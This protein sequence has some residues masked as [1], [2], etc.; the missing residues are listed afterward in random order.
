MTLVRYC[1]VILTSILIAACGPETT[2][3]SKDT[4]SEK[5]D[6]SVEPQSAP[7]SLTGE[8]DTDKG[9]G[10][11]VIVFF[12]DSITAGFGVERS[13]AFPALIEDRFEDSGYD[14]VVRNAGV[15]GET[16]AGGL[17]RIDWV[18]NQHI[19]VIVIE[20]GGNDGLRGIP[21]AETRS[22]LEAIIRKVKETYPDAHVVL[23][24]M[25]L[26]PNLGQTY[27]T[28]FANLFSEVAT[29]EEV[30]LIPFILE[31]V[32]GVPELNQ[33][34]GI[35]PTASGHEVI[36][37]HIWPTMLSVVEDLE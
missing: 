5:T 12:G 4:F 22:N 37:E 10:D 29:A 24:G 13:Q 18:L 34:D 26:P 27:T 3:D 25:Q 11:K 8:R 14:I 28:A 6:A 35:H 1:F 15:S 16:T 7:E 30:T 9:N 19:D 36:A 31:G 21:V 2:S 33:S 20:L 17:R 23:A 32:G